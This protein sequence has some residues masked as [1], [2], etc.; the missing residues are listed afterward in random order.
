[1][2]NYFI[3][4]LNNRQYYLVC[5]D[6]QS[7]LNYLSDI[8]D[9]YLIQSNSGELIIDQLL[10]AGNG[11]NR[12]LS[13]QFSHGEIKLDTAKNITATDKFKSISSEVLAQNMEL[14]KYSILSD[15]QLE[16]IRQGYAV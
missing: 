9:E 14:L 12:F 16:L 5:M 6:Y 1:M 7:V 8:E 10:V 2:S 4:Q 11:K 15:N 13:C 3:K